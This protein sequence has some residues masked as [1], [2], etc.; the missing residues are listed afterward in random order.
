[1]DVGLSGPRDVVGILALAGDE[2]EI[3]LAADCR[4]DPGR[5]HGVSS[6]GMRL[7]FSGLPL[8]AALSH[9]LRAGRDR[10]H[11]VVVAG[12]AADVAFE[13]LADR[14]VVEAVALAL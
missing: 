3:F 8:R 1:M 10:L 5:A 2:P 9:R 12:A 6:V 13:L 11:D 14:L 7:I 4:A